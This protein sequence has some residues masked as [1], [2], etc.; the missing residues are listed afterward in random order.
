MIH[1]N[2]ALLVGL[3]LVGFPGFVRSGEISFNRDIRPI[4]SENCFACHG[5]DAVGR[6]ADLRLDQETVA[7]VSS[8][9]PDGSIVRGKPDES[10]LVA[11][12]FST[13]PDDIMP[14]PDSHKKLTSEQRQLLQQWIEEGAE[15]EDHWAFVRPQKPAVPE[16]G[17]PWARNEIDQFVLRRLLAEKLKPSEEADKRTLIR[18]VTFDLTG[19][20]PAIAEVEAFMADNSP[21]AYE[22]L[23]DRLLNSK[24]YGEHRARYWLDAARYGDTHGLHLDNV[25]EIWPYRDWVIGAYNDNLPFDQFT[26]EQL[27]GDLLPNAT[28]AQRVATG[29]NRCNVTTSEGGA[30]AE[31][32]LVRY[33]VDRVNTTST[34]WLGLTG[35]CAQ[36]HDHKYDPM[37]MRDYYQLFAYFNNTT[38]PG[39]D[40]NSKESPP[41][42][43]VYPSQEEEILAERLRA[44]VGGL[45]AE[46][47]EVEKEAHKQ[48]VEWVDEATPFGAQS[49]ANMVMQVAGKSEGEPPME[50]PSSAAFEKAKPFTIAFRYQAPD[51]D[52]RA[53]LLAQID[54][55]NADRGWRV[56]WEDWGIHIELIE[57]WPNQ[58]LRS[59]VTRRV[60]P[61]SSGHFAI[62]YDGSGSSEGLRLYMNGRALQ[63]RFVNDWV[64]SLEGDFLPSGPLRIGGLSESGDIAAK[65]VSEVRIFDRRLTDPEVQTLSNWTRLAG[66]L[67]KP[68]DKRSDKEKGEL[69]PAF[70]QVVHPPYRALLAKKSEAETR[71]SRIEARSPYTLVME[72]KKDAEPKAHILERGEYDKPQEEVGIGVPEFLPRLAENA[73]PNRL[74]LAQWLVDPDHPLTARV[75][76]NRIWQEIFGTGLVKTSEDFGTQG[77]P[78]SHPELLD[79]LAVTFVESGWDMK[80]LYRML[81]M[82][83]TYR[84]SSRVTPELKERDPENRLLARGSRYRLDAEVLRD[85]ALHTSGLLN[86][87]VGGPGV[88]PWQPAGIWQV[89]GYTNSNTQTF[90]PDLGAAEHRRTVYTF[91]KRT[92]PPPNLAIFDAPNREDCIVRRERTNTPLQAL[93]LMNDPQFVRAT[94]FL[95]K[96]AIEA[97]NDTDDRI[98]YLSMLLR[99]RPADADEKQALQASLTK[100]RNAWSSQDTGA[101][102]F[103][104]DTVNPAFSLHEVKQPVELASWAMVASQLLNLDETVSRN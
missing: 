29:F 50:V 6:K 65:S 57:S 66:I 83:A 19:L 22:K 46:L 59:G 67:K 9:N 55:D 93:V 28:Q 56:V 40:G 3:V 92:A 98:D 68:A 52:G 27:A 1:R 84:Q 69:K 60:R 8:E 71:L 49:L 80:A 77:E 73:P 100:I 35:Q 75:T 11:R 17:E 74:G 43:R 41:S 16:T 4:L 14:P 37:T 38:Q 39:M 47:K 13:D 63:S 15:W 54:P 101:R 21:D 103:L 95:A 10:E 23:V 31:E 2:T 102:D 79:W 64:D 36:C 85:L 62:S 82:S 86:S 53:I 51:T 88:R 26:V 78:P 87:K 96:R 81:L 48:F 89:V 12:V 104:T 94:R 97:S 76:V 32:F 90:R 33:A 25:R 20:P 99:G 45:D 18:R 70:F 72:D 58:T 91:W 42:I 5:P 61:G 44:E 7:V 24:A 34:V 30:I